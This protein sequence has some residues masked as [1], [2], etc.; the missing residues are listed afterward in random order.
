MG[1]VPEQPLSSFF[2]RSMK[3]SFSRTVYFRQSWYHSLT[4]WNFPGFLLPLIFV[5]DSQHPD[6]QTEKSEIFL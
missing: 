5:T 2:L 6:G 1:Q 3:M 4:L